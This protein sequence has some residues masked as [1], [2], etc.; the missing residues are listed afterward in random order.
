MTRGARFPEKVIAFALT[1]RSRGARWKDIQRAIKQEFHIE[2]PS[3]RQMRTWYKEYGGGSIDPEKMLREALIKVVRGL[4]PMVAFSTQ[5]WA[6]QQIPT[7]MKAR[8]QN[9]DPK[10][11]WGIMILD[12]L[13]ETVGRDAYDEIVSGYQKTRDARKEEDNKS[14]RPATATAEKDFQEKKRRRG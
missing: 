8:E 13:E 9:I 5:E 7:L 3:E 10:V 1:E 12:M 14:E 6:I 2:P 11:A 4:T